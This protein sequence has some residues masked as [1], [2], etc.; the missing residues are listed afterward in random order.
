[1]YQKAVTMFYIRIKLDPGGVKQGQPRRDSSV[2]L[3]VKV[4][5]STYF[6]LPPFPNSVS[7]KN[8]LADDLARLC[9]KGIELPTK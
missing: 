9:G 3:S 4:A 8:Q 1:M 5:P 2:T 7:V 6:H